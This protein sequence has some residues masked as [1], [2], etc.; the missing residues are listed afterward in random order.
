MQEYKP[1]PCRPLLKG[2]PKAVSLKADLT[3]LQMPHEPQVHNVGPLVPMSHIH[4]EA[5]KV[6]NSRI[7][8]V[9]FRCWQYES[10]SSAM[11]GGYDISNNCSIVAEFPSLHLSFH[12]RSNSL[13]TVPELLIFH[14]RGASAGSCAHLAHIWPFVWG[15]IL[16]R[17]HP[18][19][20]P[21][22]TPCFA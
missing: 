20:R 18:C 17:E 1:F 5:W 16:Q 11:A 3:M 12:S 19:T 15:K 8:P 10:F 14:I 2:A 13:H 4:W 21:V 7:P 6:R 22:P 9:D